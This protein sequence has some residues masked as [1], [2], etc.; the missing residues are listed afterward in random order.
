MTTPARPSSEPDPRASTWA[1]PASHKLKVDQVPT[2]AINLNVNGRELVGPL[3]GFGQLWQKTY[4]VRLAGTSVTP[5][6]LIETWKQNFPKFWPAGNRFYGSLVGIKPGEVA[7]LNLAMP[8]GMPLST[9]V[10]VLYADD[11]S[12]TLM[13]PQGHMESGWITFSA[14]EQD[15]ATVAQ[16]ESMARA[17]DPAYEIGFLLFA[18]G[19]QEKFWHATLTAL[20]AH[21]GV[22]GQVQMRK[23]CVDS[24]WQWNQARNLWHNAAMRTGMY[25]ALS[26]V[27]WLGRLFGRRA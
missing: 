24:R 16:V 17:N 4:W 19:T 25:V 20:A 12:F 23:I 3:Q 22:N 1:A 18:H 7:V 14:F 9:G 13:T 15:G 11:V 27:R 10:M 26:P 2:G 21:F 5:Q 8:G 6:Q